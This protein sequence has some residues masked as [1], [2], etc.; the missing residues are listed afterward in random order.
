MN[1]TTRKIVKIEENVE[2]MRKQLLAKFYRIN[3]VCI[4]RPCFRAEHLFVSIIILLSLTSFDNKKLFD[5]EMIEGRKL[6][7]RK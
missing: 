3:Y 4:G 5:F 1:R 2:R 7:R 6:E